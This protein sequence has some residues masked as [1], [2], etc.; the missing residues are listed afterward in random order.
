MGEADIDVGDGVQSEFNFFSYIIRTDRRFRR[1][2]NRKLLFTDPSLGLTPHLGPREEEK[3]SDP[4]PKRSTLFSLEITTAFQR[5]RS[6]TL[7]GCWI[8]M[9]SL[10]KY[11]HEILSEG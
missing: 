1:I 7:S 2:L 9:P 11:A 8:R 4:E 5:S 6:C 10:V 3:G